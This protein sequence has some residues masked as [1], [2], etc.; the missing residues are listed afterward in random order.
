[1]SFFI[2]YHLSVL[3]HISSLEPIGYRA[4]IMTEGW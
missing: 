3:V 4:D 2:S 1:M